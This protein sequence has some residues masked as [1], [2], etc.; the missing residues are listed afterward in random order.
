M[1]LCMQS[2][3][4]LSLAMPDSGI[5]PLIGLTSLTFL[6]LKCRMPSTDV[7]QPTNSVPLAAG[8]FTPPFILCNL[9]T[10]DLSTPGAVVNAAA[11]SVAEST[12]TVAFALAC[13]A[14]TPLAVYAAKR[15]WRAIAPAPAELPDGSCAGRLSDLAQMQQLEWLE[16]KSSTLPTAAEW[17]AALAPL[18]R[19]RRLDVRNTAF[20]DVTALRN[21]THLSVLLV[22]GCSG[23]PRSDRVLRDKAGLSATS[24]VRR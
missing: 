21:M 18:T 22:A 6:R 19:L 11:T 8:L 12:V 3:Q 23:L 24:E 9:A 15:M 16:V 5:A 13:A 10:S 17:S 20:Q 14:M 7:R 1:R 4:H 2:L